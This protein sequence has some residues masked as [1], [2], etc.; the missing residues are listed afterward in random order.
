MGV[1]PRHFG[2]FMSVLDR[3]YFIRLVVFWLGY[4]KV[5]CSKSR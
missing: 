2:C 4:A 5:S 3:C 1:F